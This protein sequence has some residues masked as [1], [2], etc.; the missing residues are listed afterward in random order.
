MFDVTKVLN[1]S[2]DQVIQESVDIKN[3][4]V[5]SESGEDLRMEEKKRE[6]SKLDE[7]KKEKEKRAAEE[8]L[9]NREMK[10]QYDDRKQTEH[11]ASL[12]GE[13]QRL[14]KKKE[15]DRKEII[16]AAKQNTPDTQQAVRA[17]NKQENENEANKTS[18]FD[19][20]KK[21]VTNW[22][23]EKIGNTNFTKGQATGAAA[24]ALAAGAGALA[25]RKML[26]NRKKLKK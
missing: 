16:N 2:L 3:N 20:I 11:N 12:T 18:K 19:D 4:T 23:S 6:Q 22:S 25:L 15:D 13:E 8:Y 1:S 5:L 24:A 21:N 9:K 7:M 10:Q 17:L 26:K 14:S